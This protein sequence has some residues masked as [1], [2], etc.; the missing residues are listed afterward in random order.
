MWKTASLIL[1]LSSQIASADDRW[2]SDRHAKIG[3]G[4]Y[5]QHCAVCHGKSAE[6]APNWTK[7]GPDGFYPPP[8][9]N[10]TAHT[11]HHPLKSL[12]GTIMNGQNKMPA[13]QGKLR[14]EETLAIIAWFQS[15]WS[16][17]VYSA[18]KRMDGTL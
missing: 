15:Q 8:P 17:E 13:W 6:G 1:L 14:K 9:L 12:Y 7:L 11:W 4:L 3:A 16:D 18:W 2:Y 5:Q 10:G